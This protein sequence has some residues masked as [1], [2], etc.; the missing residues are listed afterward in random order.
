ML[1]RA[2]R[3]PFHGEQHEPG[4]RPIHELAADGYSG[5]TGSLPSSLMGHNDWEIAPMDIE[6]LRRED[7]SPWELGTGAFGKVTPC[8]QP[9]ARGIVLRACV[10][11]AVLC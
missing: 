5:E 11:Q 2:G 8:Q 4:Q 7:G 6:I 1:V 3:G 9:R 10:P